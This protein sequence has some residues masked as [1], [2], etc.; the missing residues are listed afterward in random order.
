MAVLAREGGAPILG[1]LIDIGALV[2]LFAGTL[3]CITAAARVLLRMAHEGLAQDALKTTHVRNRT[4]TY[5]VVITGVA[6]VLPVAV[7]AARGASGLDVYGWMGT[8]ATYGFIVAY[9]LVCLALPRYLV[10]HHA[11]T[12]S[13]RILSTLAA[14]AM[15]LALAGNLYPVPEGPYGRLPYLYLAYLATGLGWFFLQARG[16]KR[17]PAA[18]LKLPQP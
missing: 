8:L 6:A 12:A 13:S 18:G 3:A 16:R 15:L 11:R 14:I 17:M 5:A 9:A 10:Q 7:L 4:P 1:L 2:S